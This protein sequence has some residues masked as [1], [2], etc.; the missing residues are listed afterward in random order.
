MASPSPPMDTPGMG[1]RPG[2]PGPPDPAM[3]DRGCMTGTGFAAAGIRPGPRD[4]P[5]PVMIPVAMIPWRR[6]PG[7]PRGMSMNPWG[8]HR[9][10]RHRPPPSSSPSRHPRA[11]PARGAGAIQRSGCGAGP[12]RAARSRPTHRRPVALT[13][14]PA[15]HHQDGGRPLGPDAGPRPDPSGLWC[16]ARCPDVTDG[17][18]MTGGGRM[19][20]PERTR[21]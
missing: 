6:V 4:R 15:L 5:V 9:P 18:S 3:R 12:G 21:P 1:P 16:R 14:S 2:R 8:R 13:S 10:G 20:R 19:R 17:G 11:P 7:R